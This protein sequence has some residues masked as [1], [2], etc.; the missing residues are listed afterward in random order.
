[1]PRPFPHVA[2]DLR[3]VTVPELGIPYSLVIDG[4][5]E[6]V[7]A[8]R[9]FVRR[10]LGSGH[11]GAERVTLLISEVVTNSVNHSNSRLAGGT[12][13][14]TL[15]VGADCVLVEVIDDGGITV[16]TLRRGD[17]LAESGRG[18]RLVD[19]YSRTWGYQQGVTHTVT[20]FEC[21]LEPL[22]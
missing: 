1:M 21:G 9:A 10:V 6:Q 22:P 18:L 16:P 7:G 12:V 15:R 3:R 8:A 17:D 14:V 11:P 5:P 19:A 4:V 20:W 2:A 13:T